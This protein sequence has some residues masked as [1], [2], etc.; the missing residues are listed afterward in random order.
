MSRFPAALSLMLPP[1]ELAAPVKLSRKKPLLPAMTILPLVVVTLTV[2]GA[3]KKSPKVV[4]LTGVGEDDGAGA[5]DLND[6]HAGDH[7]PADIQTPII[8]DED[9]AG[10]G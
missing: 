2:A 5:G 3:L 6:V 4:T 8:V 9:C 1:E 10:P 7:A